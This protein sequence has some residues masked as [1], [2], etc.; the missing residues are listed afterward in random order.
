MVTIAVWCSLDYFFS[1]KYLCLLL[2][3]QKW[4]VWL[5]LLSL[6]V[7]GIAVMRS[8]FGNF[9]WASLLSVSWNFALSFWIFW[10]VCILKRPCLY[11]QTDGRLH[12]QYQ[13]AY[14]CQHI[15]SFTAAETKC[16]KRWSLGKGV[17]K[18]RKDCRSYWWCFQ[19]ASCC[20]K[21][22]LS[23][24]IVQMQRVH[25]SCIGRIEN[26]VWWYSQGIAHCSKPGTHLFRWND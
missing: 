3:F 11:V 7:A 19:E 10:G 9:L 6:G 1:R 12:C 14:V 2:D 5:C 8:N 17:D 26:K 4:V 16:S 23:S 13:L 21:S 18:D 24:F 22:A 25:W 15:L 20:S